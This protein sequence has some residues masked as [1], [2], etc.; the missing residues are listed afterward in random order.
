[1]DLRWHVNPWTSFDLRLEM[2]EE[3]KAFL[4][5]L[6]EALYQNKHQKKSKPG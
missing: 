3:P 2:K 4:Q 6:A 1:M 5:A